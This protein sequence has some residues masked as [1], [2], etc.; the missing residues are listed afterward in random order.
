[1]YLPKNK[2][3]IIF[4]IVVVIII[5]VFVIIVVI[6]FLTLHL[7]IVFLC[8]PFLASFHQLEHSVVYSETIK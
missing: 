7:S 5:V 8:Q 2:C 1:M 3:A 6:V 4:Y